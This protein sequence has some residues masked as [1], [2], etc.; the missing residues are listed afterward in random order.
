M[1][2]FLRVGAARVVA[3]VFGAGTMTLSLYSLHVVLRTPQVW[4]DEEPSAYV[5]HVLFLLWV[6][7]VVVGLGRRGPLERAVGA[8]S[9]LSPSP[10]TRPRSDLVSPR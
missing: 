5:V 6:G 4:P 9:R 7:A 10:L 8:A 2:G 3:M 1:V